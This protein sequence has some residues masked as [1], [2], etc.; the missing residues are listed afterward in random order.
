MVE[1]ILNGLLQKLYQTGG[2]EN[3]I[4]SFS[5]GISDILGK[6]TEWPLKLEFQI[7]N[8]LIQLCLGQYLMWTPTNSFIVLMKL[9]FIWMS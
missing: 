7:N 6:N 5:L 9:K 4:L 2:I 3:E 1:S 8:I